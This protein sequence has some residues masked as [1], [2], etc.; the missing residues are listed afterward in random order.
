MTA[1]KNTAKKKAALKKTSPQKKATKPAEPILKIISTSKCSTIS[2]KST[3]TYNVGVDDEGHMHI[4]I[5]GNT[6]GGFFSNEWVLIDDITG[7]LSNVT[8]ENITSINLIP[9]FRGKSVNTPG[10]LLAALLNEKLLTPFEDKKRQFSYTGAKT[11]STKAT[12]RK[13]SK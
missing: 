13:A 4:R 10:Y 5:F 11:L 8:G 12:K 2:G 3:L 1:K 6:G 7:L 9:L